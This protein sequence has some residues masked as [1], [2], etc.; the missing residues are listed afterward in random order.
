VRSLRAVGASS[1][2]GVVLAA[3]VPAAF[4]AASHVPRPVSGTYKIEKAFSDDVTGTVLVNKAGSTASHLT[5]TPMNAIYCATKTLHV[6]GSFHLF[7]VADAKGG[8]SDNT[9]D[10]S[11]TKKNRTSRKV[12]VRQGGTTFKATLSLT[13]GSKNGTHKP[14]KYLEGQLSSTA[15]TL[16]IGGIHR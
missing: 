8:A 13:F 15:C 3:A 4:A 12:T 1:V 16:T 7:N 9:P 6:Q 5:L 11:I 2:I 10:W 14:V